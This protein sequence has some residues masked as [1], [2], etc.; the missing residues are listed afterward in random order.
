MKT[1]TRRCGEELDEAL[2]FSQAPG[3]ALQDMSAHGDSEIAED[4]DLE[5]GGRRHR[6]LAQGCLHAGFGE[7][8]RHCLLPTLRPPDHSEHGS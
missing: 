1:V 6:G 8:L 3:G 4:L 7:R 5:C 2:S